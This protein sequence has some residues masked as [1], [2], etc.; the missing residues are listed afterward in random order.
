MSEDQVVALMAALL[1]SSG[2]DEE[3]A[4]AAALRLQHAAWQA[5]CDR[6]LAERKVG[7]PLEPPWT[8]P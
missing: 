2:H 3:C 7:D 8:K 5:C 6:R 1:V 4:L